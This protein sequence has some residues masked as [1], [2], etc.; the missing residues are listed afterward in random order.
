MG[1]AV[2]LLREMLPAYRG[3]LL[4]RVP[5]AQRRLIVALLPANNLS[6]IPDEAST[7]AAVFPGLGGN[8]FSDCSTGLACAIGWP[9]GLGREGKHRAG[10]AQRHHDGRE[11]AGRRSGGSRAPLLLRRLGIG[12]AVS[13]AV[14]E[15]TFADVFG[16]LIFLA[17][18]G[19]LIGALR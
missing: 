19:L 14:F 13:A 6:D 11:P 5:R 9:A 4:A 15:T 2:G 17:A 10:I 16:F 1:V 8:C 7:T 12:P 18:G 3:V